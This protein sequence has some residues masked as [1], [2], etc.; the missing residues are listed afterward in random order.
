MLENSFSSINL[1]NPHSEDD[2]LFREEKIPPSSLLFSR[3]F[4]SIERFFGEWGRNDLFLS[5]LDLEEKEDEEEKINPNHFE[6][7]RNNNEIKSYPECVIE[8]PKFIEEREITPEK[9]EDKK[10][11][12]QKKKTKNQEVKKSPLFNIWKVIRDGLNPTVFKKRVKK[13]TKI[14]R[15]RKCEEKK[16]NQK[17]HNMMWFDNILRKIQNHYLTFIIDFINVI[18]QNIEST[19]NLK[20]IQLDYN[21]KKNVKKSFVKKLQ[22]QSLVQLLQEKTSQKFKNY[23]RNHNK[24]TIEEIKQKA[25]TFYEYLK[26]HLYLDFF[27]DV[28]Y[29]SER[30]VDLNKYGVN[31]SVV[32]PNKVELYIDLFNNIEFKDEEEE[33]EYKTKAGDCINSNFLLKPKFIS[34]LKLNMKKSK[35]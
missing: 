4:S 9:D 13:Y 30:V 34:K 6:E 29:K 15:G 18:L 31:S 12:Q 8:I 14:K 21:Y 17:I 19:K 23:S 35:K 10:E 22:K 1:F 5:N 7:N 16:N 20:L 25:N 33:K 2:L 28:Y 3:D 32:L 11:N 26:S 27:K 24:E